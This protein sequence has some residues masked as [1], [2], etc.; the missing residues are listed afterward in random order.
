MSK[1]YMKSFCPMTWI[2]TKPRRYYLYMY[3]IKK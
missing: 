2:K 3:I 1:N